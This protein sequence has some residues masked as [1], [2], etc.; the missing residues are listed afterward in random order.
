MQKS[1]D[2]RDVS[3]KSLEEKGKPAGNSTRAYLEKEHILHQS[4][5]KGTDRGKHGARGGVFRLT[6]SRQSG[7]SLEG[8]GEEAGGAGLPNSATG[9]GR[10]GQGGRGAG[11]G[12]GAWQPPAGPGWP[13]AEPRWC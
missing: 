12:A 3:P 5:L 13:G 1:I 11:G 9:E 4:E 6:R 2:G 7:V 8:A 10:G